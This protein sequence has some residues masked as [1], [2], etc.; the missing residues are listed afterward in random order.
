MLFLVF[1]IFCVRLLL[2]DFDIFVWSMQVD[3]KRYSG[4]LGMFGHQIQGV[5]MVVRMAYSVFDQSDRV[6]ISYMCTYIYIQYIHI[7]R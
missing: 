2:K 4:Q 3:V 1:L 5:Q 6:D 7:D